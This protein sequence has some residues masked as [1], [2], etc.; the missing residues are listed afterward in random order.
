M[1]LVTLYCRADVHVLLTQL[2][3]EILRH[4]RDAVRQ[5]SD[6]VSQRGVVHTSENSVEYHHEVTTLPHHRDHLG[7]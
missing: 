3:E 5:H 6:C 7:R 1:Y 2:Q 4:E